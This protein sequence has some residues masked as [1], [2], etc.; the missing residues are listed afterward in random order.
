LQLKS[1]KIF[2]DERNQGTLA[3]QLASSPAYKHGK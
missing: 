1:A 3:S 2:L